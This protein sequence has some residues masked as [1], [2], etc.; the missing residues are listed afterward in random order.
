MDRFM[1]KPWPAGWIDHLDASGQ[2]IVDYAPASTLYHM[3]LAT[4]EAN[5]LPQQP[6]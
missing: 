1:G 5:R 2:P 4:A 6:N 3:V